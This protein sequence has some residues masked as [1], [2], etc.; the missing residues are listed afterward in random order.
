MATGKLPFAGTSTA[1]VFASL[2]MR[3]PEPP[4]KLNPG[5]SKE[6]ERIILKLLAKDKTQRYQTATE[7]R[8]RPRTTRRPLRLD[9]DC[10][11]F[12]RNRRTLAPCLP[13]HSC[14]RRHRRHCAGSRRLSLVARAA[15]RSKGLP[16]RP[17]R[18]SPTKRLDHPLRL[19]QPDRRS[20]L[21]HHTEP[22]AR[23]SAGAIAAAHHRQR[24]PPAPEPQ[25][26]RQAIR[27]KDHSRD[28]P[29]DRRPRGHQGNHQWYHLPA[30]QRLHRD[31][32][33]PVNLDRRLDRPRAGPG[34]R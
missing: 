5:I 7:V 32:R 18:R 22:G 23:D 13:R 19:P 27:R 4:R 16:V 9:P 10:V 14:R 21:R 24:K 33:G 1:D 15:S 6:G 11:D 26:S 17:L 8:R 3:E 29:R 2:L 31:P 20:R 30:R 12:A 28:R 34:L 25:I